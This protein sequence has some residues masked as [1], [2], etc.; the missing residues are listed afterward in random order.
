M[1]STRQSTL[2]SLSGP[3]RPNPFQLSLG[4]SDFGDHLTQYCI[5]IFLGKLA[6]TY[7]SLE[8]W[9]HCPVI[10]KQMKVQAS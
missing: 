8:V 4:H 10:E 7:C 6:L 1:L 3:T 9:A 5:V 2:P